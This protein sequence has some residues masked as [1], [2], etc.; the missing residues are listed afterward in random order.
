MEAAS[1]DQANPKR[2]IAVPTNGFQ[3]T[4]HS[5]HLYPYVVVIEK[6][7]SPLPELV[8]PKQGSQWEPFLR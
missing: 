5:V 6:R 3:S 2:R 4:I 1:S 7:D 8:A